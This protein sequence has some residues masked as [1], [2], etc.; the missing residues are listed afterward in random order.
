MPSL[1]KPHFIAKCQSKYLKDMKLNIPQV[2]CIVLLDFSEIYSFIVQDAIQGFHWENSQAT[3][4]PL[5]VYGR[6]SEN[7]LLTV[8]VYH[9]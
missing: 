5:V 1:T 7:Q 2:E 6:N 4:H 9:K 3:V 8:S